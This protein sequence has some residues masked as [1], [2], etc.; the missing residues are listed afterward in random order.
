M[1]F[2]MFTYVLLLGIIFITGSLA[3]Q[4]ES[5]EFA[6]AQRE[7]R[8]K[9]VRLAMDDGTKLWTRIVLPR[10]SS[11]DDPT[12][13]IT[14]VMDRSPYG[15]WGIESLTD[16]YIPKGFAAVCQDMRGTKRSGGRFSIWHSD[17]DDG[18]RTIQWVSEQ[19]WS[20]GSILSFGASADGLASFTLLDTHP[21]E[22]D[23]QFIIW[24]SAQGYPIIFPGGAYRH[25]LADSW[26]AD[27]VRTWE[28]DRCIDEVKANEQPGDWW[29]PLNMTARHDDFKVVK[30]PTLLWAG[31]YDIFL[32]G[33][34]I[35]YD[36]Y[37]NHADPANLNDV[38]IFVDPLGHCQE[39][40]AEFPTNTVAGRSALPLLMS[41]EL[42]M[43]TVTGQPFGNA[44]T[45]FM[46]YRHDVKDVT[47]YVLGALEDDASGNYWT[48]MDNFPEF[49]ATKFFLGEDGVLK[50]NSGEG[51][52]R[53]Y[54]ADPADP[55]PSLGGSNLFLACGP[56]DQ[57]PNLD[58][59]DVLTYTTEPFDA[60]MALTGPLTA[61]LSVTS[62]VVDTDFYVKIMDVYPTGEH[63]LIQEGAVRMR[64]TIFEDMKE[65]ETYEVDVDMWNTSYVFSAGH[66]IGV[67]VAS[68]NYPRFS[69]NP[70]NGLSLLDPNLFNQNY[71]ATNG[72][73]S[74]SYVTLPV[75]SLDQLPRS[76]VI[77]EINEKFADYASYGVD[78]AEK[79]KQGFAFAAENQEIRD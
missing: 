34:M 37:K 15:Y 46:P 66:S 42:Y 8:V 11:F 65:G 60:A 44:T 53:T 14:A 5:S 22:L 13:N 49:V 61:H 36:G 54:K 20:S 73:L 41:Y 79:A 39:G 17:A 6:L 70:H 78:L 52:G 63:K 75:V 56:Y 31:W 50:Q 71:T 38:K 47:F 3:V 45:E 35:A 32:V 26:M 76:H 10:G 18:A 57:S 24:S 23:A 74:S 64:N 27:T 40:A 72:V 58:R 12:A 62:D 25:S 48:T 1:I 29:E 7:R 69:N 28:S 19:I 2:K 77:E 4:E 9:D 67:T 21:E 68:S 16:L 30:W 51:T 59:S 43:S 33:Q 55:V